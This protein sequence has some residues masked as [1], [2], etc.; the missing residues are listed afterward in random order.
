[1]E[2]RIAKERGKCVEMTVGYDN[3]V[4]ALRRWF[5]SDTERE[6]DMVGRSHGENMGPIRE[7]WLVQRSSKTLGRPNRMLKKLIETIGRMV[8]SPL[9]DHVYICT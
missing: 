3:D 6:E 5:A 1:L 9:A 8:L 7:H 4:D 2:A